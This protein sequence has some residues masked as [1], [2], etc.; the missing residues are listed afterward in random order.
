MS[1]IK[2]TYR[3]V[4]KAHAVKELLEKNLT[5]KIFSPTDL[6]NYIDA[7]YNA[8]EENGEIENI[9]IGH[10][11]NGYQLDATHCSDGSVNI[12][13]GTSCCGERITMNFTKQEAIQL[14]QALIK[15]SEQI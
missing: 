5:I 3:A 15:M 13:I 10:I 6:T 9:Q 2:I 14:G 7:I 12:R 8:K 4:N 11:T 1:D